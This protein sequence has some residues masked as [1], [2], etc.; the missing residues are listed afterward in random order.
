[1]LPS[2]SRIRK[3]IS[4]VRQLVAV[5]HGCCAVWAARMRHAPLGRAARL[6]RLAA[7]FSGIRLLPEARVRGAGASCLLHCSC[8]AAVCCA[9]CILLECILFRSSQVGIDFGIVISTTFVSLLFASGT[10]R[11]TEC[12]AII[13]AVSASHC[14]LPHCPTCVPTRARSVFAGPTIATKNYGSALCAG[15][16]GA[17]LTL[18]TRPYLGRCKISLAAVVHVVARPEALLAC[19][20]SSAHDVWLCGYV[21]FEMRSAVC[22]VL[23]ESI[24]V[25]IASGRKVMIA[26]CAKSGG[27]PHIVLRCTIESGGD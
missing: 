24:V 9:G 7:A 26:V 20:L 27:V 8:E 13:S 12:L 23:C 15:A 19:P 3:A 1:M 10:S 21:L 25:R 22:V 2:V 16:R 14:T 17:R 18:E 6:L 4:T 11:P 5:S